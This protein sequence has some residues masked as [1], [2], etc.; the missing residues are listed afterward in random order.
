MNHC[1]KFFNITKR[2]FNK[3]KIYAVHKGT[4]LGHLLLYIE[5]NKLT[6]QHCFLSIKNMSNINVPVKDALEGL[7]A[8]LLRITDIDLPKDYRTL[9]LN[10]YKFNIDN[11]NKKPI[12]EKDENI[13]SGL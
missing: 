9:C 1:M 5:H 11:P 8:G 6:D 4:Y 7:N 12:I 13:D 2:G 3:G 10:Q